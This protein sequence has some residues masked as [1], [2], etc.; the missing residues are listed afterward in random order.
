MEKISKAFI[1]QIILTFDNITNIR[2][3]CQRLGNQWEILHHINM[4]ILG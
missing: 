2:L 4:N 1:N 3:D